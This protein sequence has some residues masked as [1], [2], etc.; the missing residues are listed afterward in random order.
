M[1]DQNDTTPKS[2]HQTGSDE[3]SSKDF[4]W[5]WLKALNDIVNA[6]PPEI[7]PDPPVA[8]LPWL[9]LAPIFCVRDR[10]ASLHED[11]GITH[12]LSTNRMPPQ[13]LES[14]YWELR[15]YEIEHHYMAADDVL[16][17]DMMGAHWDE[18]RNFLQQCIDYQG[19]GEGDEQTTRPPSKA[20]VHCNAGMNR[21]GTIVAA[22]M[23]YFGKMDLL[24]VATVLKAKRG[25][26][27]SNSS[28]VRQLVVFAAEQGRLGDK[29]AGYSDEPI[30]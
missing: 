18:S 8:V 10:A 20:L 23:M 15:S 9:Y 24:Q 6:P 7:I 25:Y 29:P 22:A 21:S 17:Y 19:E 5:A 16:S 13:M 11:L 1:T 28:F 12:L 3:S 2:E 27:L 26:V 30:P 4:P 14:L